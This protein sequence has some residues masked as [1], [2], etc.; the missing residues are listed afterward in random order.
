MS[1]KVNDTIAAFAAIST[2]L[3][4]VTSGESLVSGLRGSRLAPVFYALSWPNTIAFNLSVGYLS[5]VFFWILVV[6][7]PE[8]SRR[9]FLRET[10]ARRYTEFKR[11]I[12][13]I[14]IWASGEGRDVQFVEDLAIDHVQFKEYFGSRNDRWYAVLNGIQSSELRMHELSLAMKIFANEVAYLLN[15]V[16]I[17][18]PVIHRVLKQLNESIIRQTELGGDLHDRVKSVGNFLW[19]ILARWN[20]VEGQAE[21]DIIEKIIERI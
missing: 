16:S 3:L 4:V 18:D 10:L 20:F 14:F 17:D 7:L 5:S 2:I 21:D 8:R 13:Q 11:E 9:R 6:Y 1:R 12:V 19:T 15:N